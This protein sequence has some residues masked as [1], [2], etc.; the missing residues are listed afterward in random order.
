MVLW[1]CVYPVHTSD[2]TAPNNE[3]QTF[4]TG[5]RLQRASWQ[6]GMA[7]HT[8]TGIAS[9]SYCFDCRALTF[10]KALHV[11]VPVALHCRPQGQIFKPPFHRPATVQA[12]LWI[13]P[14]L[15]MLDE[16]SSYKEFTTGTTLQEVQYDA[17][18]SS[19]PEPWPAYEAKRKAVW[20]DNMS[21]SATIRWHRFIYGCM[22]WLLSLICC[23]KSD[24]P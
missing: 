13:H 8:H 24:F 20:L 10:F 18:S 1:R 12:F 15:L 16:S 14:S 21:S 7:T 5:S 9:A 19:L 6:P 17:S 2:P 3:Q 4:P 23:L 11:C 22:W